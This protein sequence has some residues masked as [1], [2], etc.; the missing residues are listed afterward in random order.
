MYNLGTEQEMKDLEEQF[1]AGP[2]NPLEVTPAAGE[3]RKPTTPPKEVKKRD[4]EADGVEGKEDG[5][6]M[7]LLAKGKEKE[8][9]EDDVRM[10]GKAKTKGKKGST[11][12]NRK[13][14]SGKG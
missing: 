5:A 13:A 14:W 7:A 1:E 8:G 4:E 10:K 3:K 2:W 11:V 12:A 9:K 6:R